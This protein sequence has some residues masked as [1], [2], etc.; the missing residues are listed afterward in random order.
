MQAAHAAPASY[1]KLVAREV[2][3][4]EALLK[5]IQAP[6]EAVGDMFRALLPDAGINELKQVCDL[7]G[8]KRPDAAAVLEDAA[9]KGLGGGAGGG[10]APASTG[11]SMPNLRLGGGLS[12][13]TDM[14]MGNIGSGLREGL[15]E[16]KGLKIG[17]FGSGGSGAEDT[18][19]RLQPSEAFRSA[20]AKLGRMGQMMK[21]GF[22]EGVDSIKEA[23]KDVSLPSLPGRAPSG[24]A[25]AES[26]STAAPGELAAKARD[27]LKDLFS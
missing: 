24:G 19:P 22:S 23:S 8:M 3:R 7:K 4:A 2:N 5:V 1:G 20:G 26:S 21:A 14:K 25:S 12:G 13:L 15:G 11:M 6:P 16:F 9:A 17:N 10:R 27:R 18:G